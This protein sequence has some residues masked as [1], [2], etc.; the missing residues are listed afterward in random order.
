V[1]SQGLWA[2]QIRRIRN[3]IEQACRRA[4]RDSAKVKLI[5]VTKT[6]DPSAVPLLAG[7]GLTDVGENRWQQAREKLAQPGAEALTW[8]FIGH[9]QSNKVR[10]VVRH[11]AWIHSI[12]SESLGRLVAAEA[13]RAGKQIDVLVQVNVAAEPTKS[14]IAPEQAEALVRTLA[15]L[16]GIRLRGLMTMAP[17]SDDPEQVRWVFRT[18]RELRDDV[19]ARVGV[20]LPELS[21][22]MSGDY[23]QAVEEGAT[24]VRIGR[25]LFN[26]PVPQAEK[27][28]AQRA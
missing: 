15:T 3:D 16:S 26:P 18:L 12:D 4:G 28:G 10:P 8:H 20:P 1:N 27:D 6:L 7:A 24:M 21:M 5:G 23:V 14:G 2:E 17:A 19:Q 22:G 13:E 11:F 9:L 25:R